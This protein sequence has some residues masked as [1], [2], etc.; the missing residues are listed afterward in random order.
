MEPMGGDPQ[1]QKALWLCFGHCFHADRS[2]GT[3]RRHG[4]RVYG[5]GSGENSGYK[6][7]GTR[8]QGC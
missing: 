6:L 7:E 3:G 2:R 8:L 1:P 4:W 5:L